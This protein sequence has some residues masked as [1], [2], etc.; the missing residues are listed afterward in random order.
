MAADRRV[1]AA[2]DARVVA[3]CSRAVERLAHAVQALE[4]EALDAAG[5]LE[6]R[7]RR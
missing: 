7:R 2:G 1:D 4:L 5:P 6:D 3:R